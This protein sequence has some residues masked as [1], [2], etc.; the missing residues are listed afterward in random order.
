MGG[1]SGVL[2]WSSCAPFQGFL[3]R[4]AGT[5]R[6]AQTAPV[7]PVSPQL[8]SS[9]QPWLLGDRP[10]LGGGHAELCSHP[11]VPPLS[12]GS[13]GRDKGSLLPGRPRQL[14][15]AVRG[16]RSEPKPPLGAG[17]A[18]PTPRHRCPLPPPPRQGMLSPFPA[19]RRFLPPAEHRAAF[20]EGEEGRG[21]PLT[22][23]SL[24]R[25]VPI[26][27]MLFPEAGRPARCSRGTP[28]PADP[29][30]GAASC[31]VGRKQ[32]Q[33]RASSALL[34][35]LPGK[36]SADRS[37]LRPAVGFPPHL[38]PSAPGPC[39]GCQQELRWVP[40]RRRFG[41]KSQKC[42]PLALRWGSWG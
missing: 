39:R 29:A 25:L 28:L 11:A 6:L 24:L 21:T 10:E 38:E 41:G 14:G 2:G 18:S 22:T 26:P 7:P 36:P 31:L 8:L 9:P 4:W 3:P 34:S 27:R 19:L 23:R 42:Q 17:D 32:P 12:P 35:S 37:L 40:C 20:E 30:A 16:G 5:P 33:G 1:G 13:C 15:E